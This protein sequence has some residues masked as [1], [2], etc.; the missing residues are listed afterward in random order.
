VNVHL[1]EGLQDLFGGIAATTNSFLH[2]VEGVLGGVEESL[3]HRPVVVLGEFLDLF[4]RNGLNMLIK[5][6]RAD[7]LDEIFDSALNFVVLAAEFLRLNSDPL[8]LHLDE[9]VKSVGLRLLGQVNE[10]SLGESLQVVL[11]T[12]LHDVVNVDDELL[13]LSKTLVNMGKVTINVHGGPGK[14]D[15]TGAELVLKILQV[16]HQEGLGVGA[17]LVHD[18]VVLAQHEVKLR[19]VVLELL[20]LQEDNLGRLGNVDSNTGEALSLTDESE[21]LGVEVHVQTIVVGVTNDE[22]G[23]EASLCLLDFEGPLLP[24]QVL[25]REERVAN[26]VVLFDGALVVLLLGELWGELFHGHG[27]AVE[28]VTGPGDGAGHSG[29]VSD[30]WGC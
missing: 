17:D 29:Q 10:D 26:L 20:L 9:L 19:V 3:I 4:S 23:L 16:G 30:D 13:E 27:D 25:V 28:E 6:V 1:E 21:N 15:H 5:L 8:L 7:S 12:V 14:G 24:P 11:D 18:S 2:L 22:G